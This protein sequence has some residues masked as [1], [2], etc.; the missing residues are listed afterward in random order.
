MAH[1]QAVDGYTLDRPL[2]VAAVDRQIAAEQAAAGTVVPPASVQQVD[3][4]M[5]IANATTIPLS[6]PSVTP[7]ATIT[8]TATSPST[9]TPTVMVGQPQ[10][11]ITRNAVAGA[12]APDA[13]VMITLAPAKRFY[14]STN[15]AN[16]RTCPKRGC[17][18]VV[19]LDPA[20]PID[21]DA[22]VNGDAIDAGNSIWYRTRYSVSGCDKT[23]SP[24]IIT[25]QAL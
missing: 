19:L 25:G 23:K 8:E 24:V 2:L 1:R 13:D 12:P 5:N 6:T 18:A 16:L 3:T 4:A 15:G 22:F 14:A 17:T 11:I 9:L 7:S 21:V 10:L 20:T